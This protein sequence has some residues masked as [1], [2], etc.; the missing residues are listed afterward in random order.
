[1]LLCWCLPASVSDQFALTAGKLTKMKYQLIDAVTEEARE[2]SGGGG[3]IG[4]GIGLEGVGAGLQ[5]HDHYCHFD[6][7]ADAD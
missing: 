6:L 2:P 3:G 7:A 5:C 1:M 4:G